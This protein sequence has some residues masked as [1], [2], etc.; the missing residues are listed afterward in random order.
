MGFS[1]GSGNILLDSDGAFG[2]SVSKKSPASTLCLV[3]WSPSSWGKLTGTARYVSINTHR[4]IE[5]G[6]R[7]DLE[8]IGPVAAFGHRWRRIERN[9]TYDRKLASQTAQDAR[10][11]SPRFHFKSEI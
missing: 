6:R 2:I 4:G 7:D 9:G 8:A 5:Q 10:D 11:S 1:F 3:L